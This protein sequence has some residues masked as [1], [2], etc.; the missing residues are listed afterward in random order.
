MHL[1][2]TQATHLT[3]ECHQ[4]DPGGSSETHVVHGDD[5]GGADPATCGQGHHIARAQ[6]PQGILH[7][8]TILGAA[9]SRR[10]ALDVAQSTSEGGVVLE[11]AQMALHGLAIPLEGLVIATDLR[12][13]GDHTAIG[14]ELGEGGLEDVAGFRATHPPDEADR[15]V[16]RRAKARSQRVGTRRSQAGQCLRIQARMPDHDS[17]TLDVDPAPTRATGELGVL[18]RRDV[19]VVLAVPLHEP[20]EHDRACRHI[21]AKRQRLGGKDHLHQPSLEEVLHDLLEHREE[22]R[23]VSSDSA[24]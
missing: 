20:L 4:G 7:R 13:Q 19:D 18:P 24:T 14:L 12:S 5:D 15:H 1:A 2:R 11:V 3:I 6:I 8:R 9:L 16:V 23:M 21:D 10:A 22:S 17:M